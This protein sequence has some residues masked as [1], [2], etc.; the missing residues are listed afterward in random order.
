MKHISEAH[1]VQTQG[2][3]I[4]LVLPQYLTVTLQG[5]CLPSGYRGACEAWQGELSMSV[6]T[7]SL[8]VQAFLF[9]TPATFMTPTTFLGIAFILFF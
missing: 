2:M 6:S 9:Q 3:P 7:R 1:P 4:Q 8:Y 5:R